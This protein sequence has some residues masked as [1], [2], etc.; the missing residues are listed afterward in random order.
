MDKTKK[1]IVKYSGRSVGTLALYKDYLCAF[2]YTDQ[3]INEGFSI[4]PF[5]LPLE[6]RVYIPKRDPFDGVFG[7]FSD[8]LPDGW[9]RLLVDRLL[10][11]KGIQPQSLTPLDRLTIVGNAGMGGLTYEPEYKLTYKATP[12]DLDMIAKECSDI[13]NTNDTKDLDALYL[14]GGSSGGARPKIL[15][16]IDGKEWLI[17]FPSSEDPANIGEQE[18]MYS[19]CAK[20]CG[21]EMTETKLF[22]SKQCSGYFGTVRFDRKNYGDTETRNHMVSVSG[23]LET[24]HRL[25]NLDYELLLRLTLELTKDFGEVM[26]MFRLMCFNV[27]AHNRDD[28]PKNFSYIYNDVKKQWQLAPAYDLTYSY[29][30][31]GQHATTINGNGVNPGMKEL[32]ALANSFGITERKAKTIAEHVYKTVNEYN[33]KQYQ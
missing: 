2:E 15:T 32:L 28:H 33:L 3:W 22:E 14:L 12:I 20:A 6:K 27:F 21:I 8:S 5:S 4:S 23:L 30:L 9:G 17:K 1:V 29:S 13:L 24:S 26:K 11:Q 18:Y 31:G 10:Q 7:V 25:P 19:K 16:K